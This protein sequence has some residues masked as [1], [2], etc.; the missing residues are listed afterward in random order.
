MT[1]LQIKPYFAEAHYNIGIALVAK[2]RHAEAIDHFSE[3]LKPHAKLD[4]VQRARNQEGLSPYFKLGNTYENQEKLD[5]AIGQYTRA[6]S[7][8][9]E[10]L[11]ALIRLAALYSAKNDYPRALSLYQIDPSPAGLR[12]ALLHGYQ[13]WGLLKSPVNRLKPFQ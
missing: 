7:V 11:P 1:A 9:S 12:R 3:A 2:H 5:E 4:Q 8:P 13:N 6:L 10:Y